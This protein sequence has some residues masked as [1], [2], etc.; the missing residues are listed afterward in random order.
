MNGMGTMAGMSCTTTL[1]A[2][3]VGL[4]AGETHSLIALLVDNGHAPFNPPIADKVDV[5]IG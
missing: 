5:T 4:R 1:H 2:S 3:T